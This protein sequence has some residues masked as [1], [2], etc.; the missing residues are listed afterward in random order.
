MS[1]T[2]RIVRLTGVFS[3]VRVISIL[4]SVVRNKLIAVFIGPEGIGLILIYNTVIDLVA[5]ST[6]LSIDQSAQRD[7]SGAS[8][9]RAATVVTVVRRWSVWL[10]GAGVAAMLLLSPLFSFFTFD[11]FTRWAPFCTLALVPFCLTYNATVTAQNQGLKRFRQLASSGIF[12]AVSGL[13]VAVPLIVFLGIRS[14]VPVILVYG[15]SSLVGAYIFRPR[16]ASVPMPRREILSEGRGFIRLGFFITLSWV[17]MQLATYI[18]VTFLNNYASTEVLGVYQSGFT[19]MNNYVG[20][21]FTALFFEY[22]PRLAAAAHS[23]RRLALIAG[24]EARLTLALITPL[25]CL[26]ILLA[27]PVM[28]LIYSE[29]FLGAVPFVVWACVGVVFRVVSWCMA[30]VVL[31]RGDGKAYLVCEVLS[32]VV[33]LAANIVGYVAGGIVGLGI[34]YLVWYAAYTAIV[35]TVCGRR[36]GIGYGP[37]TWLYALAALALVTAVALL[38]TV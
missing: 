11:T 33:G 15:L 8:A 36:Y 28:R 25:L 6:R 17:S 13:A 1:A 23:R 12:T 35:L 18:F 16:I 20:I 7:I 26:L 22:Y 34:A 10:G 2:A 27:A 21:V 14:I 31:A 4:C 19:L 29:D 24:H 32:N 38:V 5:Q 37:R 30:Y 9:A 3:F